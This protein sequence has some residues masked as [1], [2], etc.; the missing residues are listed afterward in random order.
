MEDGSWIR[1]KSFNGMREM[2]N[3]NLLLKGNGC[4]GGVYTVKTWKD[5]HG[6]KLTTIISHFLHRNSPMIYQNKYLIM[7]T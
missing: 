3:V 5:I 6:L 2:E 7:K 4:M 1:W